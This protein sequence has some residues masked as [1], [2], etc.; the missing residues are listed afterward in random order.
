MALTITTVK[1]D[2]W[3]TKRVHIADITFDNSYPS[4][5][6]SLTAAD[7]GFANTLDA[8]FC[9]GLAAKADET[10]AVG[11]KY[12]YTA[13]KLVAYETAAAAEGPLAQVDNT[14]SLDTYVVRIMAIGH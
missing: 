4:G 6:E 3:G 5:G 2:V 10:L 8:V 14:E 1:K 12:D 7:L 13:S 11:V 9:E